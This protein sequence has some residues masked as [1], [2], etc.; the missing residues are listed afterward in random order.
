MPDIAEPDF[1]QV[2]FDYC[3]EQPLSSEQRIELLESQMA[4]L[5]EQIAALA[6]QV[7]WLT[8]CTD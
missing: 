3:P 2:D 6:E 5:R 8:A 1:K 7:N 4:E